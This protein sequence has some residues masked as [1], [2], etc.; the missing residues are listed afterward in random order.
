MGGTWTEW[1]AKICVY[2]NEFQTYIEQMH[3]LNFFFSLCLCICTTHVWL[4]YSR[5][6]IWHLM[7]AYFYNRK[8]SQ[9]NVRAQ[10]AHMHNWKHVQPIIY[11]YIYIHHFFFDWLLVRSWD[12]LIPVGCACQGAAVVVTLLHVVDS[13]GCVRQVPSNMNRGDGLSANSPSWFAIYFRH[14]T[15]S[16]T[17]A[18]KKI[19]SRKLES[20]GL[21]PVARPCW[22]RRH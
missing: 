14:V 9:W 4:K 2:H 1:H 11:I 16:T 20:D 15:I 21:Q 8:V 12:H 7:H 5:A 10:G 19:C 6:I 18:R 22:L 17:G 3:I 13:A